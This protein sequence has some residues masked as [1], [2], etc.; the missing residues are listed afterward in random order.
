MTCTH[1]LDLIDAS[2][3]VHVP[4]SQLDAAW[5]HAHECATCGPALA[6]ATL[7]DRELS[8]LQQPLPPPEMRAT[9]LSRIAR[10][11]HVEPAG[12]IA[13]DARS[14]AA[15]SVRDRSA[16]TPIGGLA[17]GLAIVL[18]GSP[19]LVSFRGI[20]AGLSGAVSPTGTIAGAL[21]LAAGLMLYVAVLFAPLETGDVH[22]RTTAR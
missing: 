13:T 10:I 6:A 9:I 19:A 22:D 14:A 3:F 20:W 17:L 8:A 4:Q 15:A 12:A 7:L 1:V 5:Q 11:E 18:L 21:V 2:P 16:W